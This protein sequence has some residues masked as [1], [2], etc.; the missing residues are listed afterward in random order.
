MT[1][2]SANDL[3]DA[4][5]SA[6]AVHRLEAEPSVALRAEVSEPGDATKGVK[7][8]ARYSV[9]P[10]PV[11]RE[12]EI[13]RQLDADYRDRKSE[14]R[15]YAALD[16]VTVMKLKHE[17]GIDVFNLQGQGKRLLQIIDRDFP[18]L[19]TTNMSSTRRGTR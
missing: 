1:S 11:L 5:A 12:A 4:G 16:M 9:D 15:R 7:W 13:H 19:K 6:P 8:H 3:V 17:Y 14:M 10:T 2:P 18:L